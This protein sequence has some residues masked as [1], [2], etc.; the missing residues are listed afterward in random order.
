DPDRQA[1]RMLLAQLRIVPAAA[2]AQGE[3]T[4]EVVL[5]Q[6]AL[7]HEDAVAGQ[8]RGVVLP[9][10]GEERAL[11]PALAV[12]ELDEG[13][14]LAAPAH[15]HHLAGH[16]RRGLLAPAAALLLRPRLP[17]PVEVA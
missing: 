8:Q 1:L 14:R 11:D 15:R 6:A 4:A 13:L 7:D 12:V 16:D 2:G 9:G 10:L 5:A 3:A 17:D